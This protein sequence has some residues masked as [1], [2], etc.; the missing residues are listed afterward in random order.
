MTDCDAVRVELFKLNYMRGE[1]V[2]NEKADAQECL[3]FLITQMHMWMQ[4]CS[5]PPNAA[6]QAIENEPAEEDIT[7]KLEKLAKVVNCKYSA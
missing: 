4:I 5:T 6:R 2:I 1:F 7:L 3:N